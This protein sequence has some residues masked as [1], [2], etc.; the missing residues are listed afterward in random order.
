[1]FYI[2]HIGCSSSISA[3]RRALRILEK[4]PSMTGWVRVR[5]GERGR[6][7]EMGVKGN[8]FRELTLTVGPNVS[9]GFLSSFDLS[10]P[11]RCLPVLPSSAGYSW[12]Q[13]GVLW[14]PNEREKRSVLYYGPCSRFLES[15]ISV[16]LVLFSCRSSPA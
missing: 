15:L 4:I 6:D 3:H 16:L 12:I 5:I 14:A 10:S 7:A 2:E 9:D 1:M 8:A 11:V 13:H